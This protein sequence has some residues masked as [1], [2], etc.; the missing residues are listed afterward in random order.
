MDLKYN[1]T[2][3]SQHTVNRLL[4]VAEQYDILPSLL[5]TQLHFETMWGSAKSA[6]A[7]NNW[8]GM[9]WTGT[10]KRPSGIVVKRG[11]A[12]PADEGGHYMRY[13][14]VDEFI[15]DWAYL[16]RP[17][18]IYKVS[19]AKSFKDAVK[20][21]FKAGGATYDYA[22]SGYDHYIKGMSARR[23]GINDQNSGALD[24]LD[25]QFL[26]GNK[27]G[28]VNM[29]VTAEELLAIATG[30]LGVNQYSAKHK[31]LVDDYNKVTPR[32]VGYAVTYG[33][34]WCDTFVTVVS[35][36]AGATELIGRECGVERHKSI[37]KQKNI[38]L[39][40][41]R[42]QVGDV[43]IFQWNGDRNGFAHHIGF[44]LEVNGNTIK[45]VEGN[46]IK[47]GVSTVGSKTYKWN[48][49]VIQG[50]ARPKYGA[51]GGAVPAVTKDQIGHFVVTVDSLR[52]FSEPTSMSEIVEDIPADYVKNFDKVVEAEGYTW[53]GWVSSA[54]GE[55][56]WTTVKHNDGRTF[57]DM[58][59]GTI[60]H[61]GKSYTEYLALQDRVADEQPVGGAE[62]KVG[63]GQVLVEGTL[64]DIVL[65]ES[66]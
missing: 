32:P 33:D 21:L 57:V 9:T 19:G 42:P 11:T 13:D 65:T 8:G 3:L 49:K 25:A 63:K 29:A 40:L 59:E 41:V 26:S 24:T 62:P 60:G 2:T 27:G 7:N 1:G 12:R 55:Y 31:Q 10:A 45:T 15:T 46:T 52:A 23:K 54:D 61:G 37:F 35:D 51:S 6:V 4:E 28:D 39:G 30:Y 34:D 47:A 56:R 18:G 17:T 50:Y 43:V 58:K 5:I 38:W 64:Y 53:V 16:L 44:V 14:S 48:D 36:K 66:K 22:A 20:G